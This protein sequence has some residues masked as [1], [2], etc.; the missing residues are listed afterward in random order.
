MTRGTLERFTIR[1]RC[2]VSG[3]AIEHVGADMTVFLS[4]FAIL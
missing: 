3:H 2:G 1:V 4:F